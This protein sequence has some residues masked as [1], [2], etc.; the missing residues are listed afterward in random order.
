MDS[1]EHV[2]SSLLQRKGY[3]TRTSVKVDL[4][5]E[6]KRAIGRPSSPRWELDVVAYK[7][8]T[9]HVYV[10]ECK[11]YI[12]SYGVRLSAF[13]GS[14]KQQ[15]NRFKLFNES[16]LREVVLNRLVLQMTE[17]GFCRP[18][19][20]VTLCLVAG[21]IY[22]QRDEIAAIFDERGWLLWDAE[23]LRE[24][25]TTLAKSGYENSVEAIVSKLL[26][27]E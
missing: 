8:R 13:D 6:E 16:T 10:I 9:N 18:N 17:R 5:K 25:L 27:R 4:T 22:N 20:S 23:W 19:P 7:A 12:D 3:W 11:S 1:F 15:A 26:L 24:E 21:N 2:V 14:S